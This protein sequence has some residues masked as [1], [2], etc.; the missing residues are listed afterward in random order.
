MNEILSF[1]NDLKGCQIE[2]IV[3]QTLNEQWNYISKEEHDKYLHTLGNLSIT[4]NNQNLSNKGFSEKKSILINTSRITLNNI[5]LEY[6]IF[7]V[8]DIKHRANKLLTLF[9]N[10]FG[11]VHTPEPDGIDRYDSNYFMS[12]RGIHAQATLTEM[13][14]KVKEGSEAV[15]NKSP[16]L[17][18]NNR[19]RRNTLIEEGTLIQKDDIL[20]FTKDKLFSSPSMAATIIAGSSMN[21]REAWKTAEGNTL[22]DLGI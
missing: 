3:P 19:N 12:H 20:I 9:T 8:N 22:N 11:I 17:S 4:F 5:L 7:D 10:E 2:H 18:L 16:N 1:E 13:G 6:D 14:L 15:L 21:G